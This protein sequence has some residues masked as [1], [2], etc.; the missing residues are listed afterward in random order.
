MFDT[1]KYF[2]RSVDSEHPSLSEP[3]GSSSQDHPV[4]YD[5]VHN[6]EGRSPD[7]SA[8]E[9]ASE[10]DD[11]TSAPQLMIIF[12]E[13][14]INSAL[15]FLIE[16]A[17]NPF[18]SNAVAVVLVEE[19]IR[20][21]IVE[22]I[23]PKLHPLSKIVA[24]HPSYLTALEKCETS[25]LNVIRACTTE[26]APPLASPT[27]VCEC[28]HDVLGSYPTGVVTFHT[29]RNNQE[30]IA[31]CRRESLAFAS[32]S[33]WNETLTGCYDLVVALSSSYFFLNCANVDVSP[34][35]SQ[36]KAQKNYVAI[37]NG[38]HFEALRIYDNFKCIV[39]PIGGLILPRIED[40]KRIEEEHQA[41]SFL[42]A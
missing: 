32:V 13:G 19:K 34:V 8:I 41:I 22:R 3:S 35:S 14:D 36:L 24:E 2:P 23:L 25:N 37:E 21:E 40:R 33:I 10:A 4:T 30:A 31:I 39:F 18:A 16:S 26:V 9:M 38:F 17:Q 27:F 11:A 5:M 7:Q 12:E 29:F 20:E 6:L 1:T 15:H 42:E 28:T